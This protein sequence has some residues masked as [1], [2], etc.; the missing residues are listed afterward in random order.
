M[1][2]LLFM[3]CNSKKQEPKEPADAENAIREVEIT[4]REI[5][6][7]EYEDYALSDAA[8]KAVAEWSGF[9]EVA[10][11]VDYLK[12]GDFTFFK[13]EIAEIKKVME[14]CRFKVTEEFFTDQIM[15]RL[16]LV[17]TRFLKLQNDLTLDNIPKEEQLN[18]IKEVLTAWSNLIYVMNKK[19]E[20][21]ETD[22][23]RP[24]KT[25]D[26]INEDNL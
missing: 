24:Q 9:Q 18:S 1:A 16:T 11:P 3:A 8:Q 12:T 13:N 7:L 10:A 22:V 14:Q 2:F 21:E 15:A 5:V 6:A 17:E 25:E 26:K 19:F 20:F 4:Q 23:E